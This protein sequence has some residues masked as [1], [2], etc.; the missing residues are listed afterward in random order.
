MPQEQ[1]GKTQTKQQAQN[2]MI[3]AVVRSHI[4]RGLLETGTVKSIAEIARANKVDGSYVSRIPDLTLLE[5][6]IIDAIL[7]SEEHSC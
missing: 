5:P 3:L 7:D 4:W 2:A 1:A 6:D